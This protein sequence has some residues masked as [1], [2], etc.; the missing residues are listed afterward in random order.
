MNYLCWENKGADELC[1]NCAADLC[2]YFQIYKI[3][4]FPMTGLKYFEQHFFFINLLFE[5]NGAS[6]VRFKFDRNQTTGQVIML[7]SKPC[8]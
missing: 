6:I 3:A 2:L 1:G 5:L 4:G 7:Y 8:Q